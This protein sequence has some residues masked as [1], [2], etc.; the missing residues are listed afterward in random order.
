[1]DINT[2]LVRKLIADQFP[3]WSDLPIK[4]V[5]PGGW[6]N[7]TFRLGNAMLV[8]M[9]S[10]ENYVSQVDKE[11]R[12]LP[13]LAKH[14]PIQI[15][16]VLALGEPGHHYPWPWSVYQWIPGEDINQATDYNIGELAISVASFIHEL[17]NVDASLGPTPG[18]H[19]YY[20]GDT[21]QLYDKDTRAYIAQLAED[22]DTDIAIELWSNATAT[23]WSKKPVWIHGDLEAS[24][25]LISNTQMNAVIDFG[26]CAVGDPACDLV[27]AWTFFNSESRASFQATL[28]IDAQT[29]ERGMAW[30][31]WKAL[32]R[33][34][35]SAKFRDDEF[36]R[37]KR[38][39]QCL[40]SEFTDPT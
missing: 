6:D 13:Y 26:N 3:Q 39:A 30:A 11:Q 4:S 16:H 29:W 9:P 33:M 8:R 14:L 12:W 40:L 24:N 34:T 31:L 17:H 21:L 38:I 22:I 19:N 7:R 28:N 5:E 37:A 20:R 15:P 10:A 36:H 25:V 35:Q 18:A 2:T 1:M 27:M 32:F 23:Q